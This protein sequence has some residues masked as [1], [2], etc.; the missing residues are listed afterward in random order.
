M[1]FK[2]K[3]LKQYFIKMER[4]PN[5]FRYNC[6]AKALEGIPTCFQIKSREKTQ[7]TDFHD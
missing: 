4:E 3:F 1:Y 6:T 7:K 5:P 2:C